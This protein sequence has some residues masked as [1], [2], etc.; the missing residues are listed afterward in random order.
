M[1]NPHGLSDADYTKLIDAGMTDEVIASFIANGINP[2]SMIG[3]SGADIPGDLSGLGD[4]LEGAIRDNLPADDAVNDGA[5]NGATGGINGNSTPN[6]DIFGGIDLQ[7]IFDEF[8]IGDVLKNN[9]DAKKAFVNAIIGQILGDQM[10]EK[11]FERDQRALDMAD[12]RA[13]KNAQQ[14]RD[15][16]DDSMFGYRDKDST[17]RLTAYRSGIGLAEGYGKDADGNY[18]KDSGVGL[19]NLNA[20]L[21]RPGSGQRSPGNESVRTGSGLLTQVKSTTG[22]SAMAGGNAF[23]ERYAEL[24]NKRMSDGL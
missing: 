14:K 4:P 9:G 23:A 2:M 22:S 17:G 8:G 18:S 15:R 7:A 13:A 24:Q 5:T 12:Q 11:N 19:L 1:S 6:A 10:S 21:Y 20:N 16:V 3:I